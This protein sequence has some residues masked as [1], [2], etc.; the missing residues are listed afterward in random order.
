[1]KLITKEV[2]YAFRALACM[3]AA[4]KKIMTVEEVAGS[5]GIPGP[6]LRKILQMLNKRKLVGSVK[7]RGGGFY[8]ALPLRKIKLLDLIEVFQGPFRLSEHFLRGKNCPNVRKCRLKEKLDSIEKYVVG[9][10]RKIDLSSL[11]A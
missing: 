5:L 2:S 7:G 4:G 1:M 3:S 6:F 11:V 10:L 9:R 8:V